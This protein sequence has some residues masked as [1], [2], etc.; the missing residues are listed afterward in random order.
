MLLLGG[1]VQPSM[2]PNIDG[3]TARIFDALGVQMMLAPR[4]GC[5]GAL[6]FNMNDQDGGLAHARRNIDAWWPYV[7]AGAEAIVMNASGCGVKVKEYGHLLARDTA[8]SAKAERIAAMTRDVS[9]ILPEFEA[10]LKAKTAGKIGKRIAY[11]SPC[12][13][14]H[15]QQIRGKVEAVLR[16]VAIDVQLCADSNLCCGSAGTYSVLQPVLSYRLRDNKLNK[17]QA[18]KP[19]MIESG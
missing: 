1:C 4:A 19:D 11:H 7:Q 15:R 16:A 5:C 12:T 6:R 8:Y 17:L 18:C 14:Q 13:L 2:A 10:P 9:E 3:A